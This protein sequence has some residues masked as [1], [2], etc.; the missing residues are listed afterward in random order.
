MIG[1][2]ILH[3]GSGGLPSVP[4]MELAFAPAQ[5][6]SILPFPVTQA[7]GADAANSV[8]TGAG[9]IRAVR[10]ALMIESAAAVAIYA[11]WRLVHLLR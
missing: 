11:L 1:R 9:C 4:Q 3:P 6:A 7:A 8:P 2:V 10:T 5:E